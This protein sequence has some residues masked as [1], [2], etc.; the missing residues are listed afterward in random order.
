MLGAIVGDVIGSVHES[1]GTKTRD[2]PLFVAGSTFTDDTV[3]TVAVADW[4]MSRQ[5]LTDVLHEYTHAYP[6]R[7]Y[8]GM[9]GQWARNRMRGPYNSYGNG[10]A[11]RVSAVGYALG[12]MEEVLDWAERSAA[13]THNH[14]EGIRGAQ[15]VAAAILLARQGGQREGRGQGRN[16]VK[17]RLRPSQKA[18]PGPAFLPL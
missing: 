11:M 9:Y 12:T 3:L 8:G 15:A 10:S 18:R 7:G 6:G 5:N 2:F 1:S 16:S 4:I 13:V 17:V 14:P